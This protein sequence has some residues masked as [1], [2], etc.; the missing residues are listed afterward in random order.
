MSRF[1]LA[2]DASGGSLSGRE[3]GRCEKTISRRSLTEPHTDT[4]QLHCHPFFLLRNDEARDGHGQ[5]KKDGGKLHLRFGTNA[6]NTEKI[7][8]KFMRNVKDQDMKLL[9]PPFAG[10]EKA[11]TR[12]SCQTGACVRPIVKD[13]V[14][15]CVRAE[16]AN[17]GY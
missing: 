14:T 15:Q 5:Q 10:F 16:R 17:I 13:F 4:Y 11:S 2:K 7:A 9:A 3:T 6:V 12:I 8:G 1:G